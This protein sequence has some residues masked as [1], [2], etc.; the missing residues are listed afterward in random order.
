MTD[1][2]V[3]S[4]S[5]PASAVAQTTKAAYES[6]KATVD[7]PKIAAVDA[8]QTVEITNTLSLISPTGLVVRFAPYGLLLIGGIAL[9]IIAMK[10]RKHNEED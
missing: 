9:L 1:N 7:T 10:H 3:S 6:T 4:G 2:N 5:A 8:L